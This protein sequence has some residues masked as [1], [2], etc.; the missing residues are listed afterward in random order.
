MTEKLTPKEIRSAIRIDKEDLA[1][2]WEE[3][4]ELAFKFNY[5]L[6]Q[7]RIILAELNNN[8]KATESRISIAVRKS[9]SDYGIDKI[10]EKAVK[11]AIEG[12]E[13]MLEIKEAIATQEEAISVFEA[14][15]VAIEHRKHALR[16]LVFL[17]GQGYNGTPSKQGL[18][19]GDFSE[20]RKSEIRRRGR[21]TKTKE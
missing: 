9:P 2:C 10:T 4:P 1:R 8:R 13:E 12:D 21:K 16:D 11:A 17:H 5:R 14:A 19:S 7:E 20:S 3:Q 6:S 18:T 15:C